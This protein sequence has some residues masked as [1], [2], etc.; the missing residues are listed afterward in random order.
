LHPAIAAP[1][2]SIQ[3][4]ELPVVAPLPGELAPDEVLGVPL[5][6][7]VPLVAFAAPVPFVPLAPVPVAPVA[8]GEP[9]VALVP[10]VAFALPEPFAPAPVAPVAPAAKP[11]AGI[12]RAITSALYFKILFVMMASICKRFSFP[13]IITRH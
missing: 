1:E 9:S 10:L 7:L 8:P 13:T 5:T 3:V 2:A 11:A 6:P 12:E 4:E